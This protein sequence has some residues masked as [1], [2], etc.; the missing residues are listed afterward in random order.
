[1]HRLRPN[2][3]RVAGRALRLHK[4]CSPLPPTANNLRHAL[5]FLASFRAAAAARRTGTFGL[6]AVAL[7]VRPITTFWLRHIFFAVCIL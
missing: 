5:R 1:M 2:V 4:N 6:V 3:T 7:L